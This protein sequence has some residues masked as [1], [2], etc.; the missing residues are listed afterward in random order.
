MAMAPHEPDSKLPELS[1]NHQTSTFLISH[2]SSWMR[3]ESWYILLQSFTMAFDQGKHF[4]CVSL[5]SLQGETGKSTLIF[6]DCLALS[7]SFNTAKYFCLVSKK[8]LGRNVKVLKDLGP[9]PKAWAF[10]AFVPTSLKFLQANIYKLCPLPDIVQQGG[11]W[12]N[13]KDR[14]V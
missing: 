3:H 5:P 2:C 8:L 4:P 14:V 11:C 12:K 10:L 9:F 13:K 6:L 7:D 1:K